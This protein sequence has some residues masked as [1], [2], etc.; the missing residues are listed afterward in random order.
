MH[1]LAA[2]TGVYSRGKEGERKPSAQAHLGIAQCMMQSMET[3]VLACGW[4]T[5]RQQ[6]GMYGV[7]EWMLCSRCSSHHM[8]VLELS[9]SQEVG[10]GG[11]LSKCRTNDRQN[12]HFL[13]KRCGYA[14]D[15]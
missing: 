13:G 10:G 15:G 4:Y 1:I 12:R 5:C 2:A 11:E 14:V 9:S 3:R 7:L 8:A 6:Q